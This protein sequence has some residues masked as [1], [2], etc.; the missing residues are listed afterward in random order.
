V[1]QA[2]EAVNSRLTLINVLYFF[3]AL[4]V[5]CAMV[6]ASPF[7]A[8]RVACQQLT[9]AGSCRVASRRVCV[10]ADPVHDTRLG[11]ELCVAC[12]GCG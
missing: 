1:G 4:L 2:L 9:L 10:C 5:I 11:Y 8:W 12:R 7:F 3:G 6:R